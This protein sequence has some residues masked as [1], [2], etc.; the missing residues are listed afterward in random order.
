MRLWS[1]AGAA[2]LADRTLRLGAGHTLAT[3][4][5]PEL[6]SRYR[7]LYPQRLARISV[8]NTAELLTL[9]AA[10][11]VEL[12]LVGS[13]AEHAKEFLHDGPDRPKQRLRTVLQEIDWG[14][15][16]NRIGSILSSSRDYTGL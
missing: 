12:A 4:L 9:V 13:P 3:Y 10:D 14:C 7:E 8:G 16:H 5:L 2:G 11:A 6:L 15:Q 1:T